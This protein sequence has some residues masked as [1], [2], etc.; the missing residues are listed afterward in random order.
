MGDPAIQSKPAADRAD[1]MMLPSS[2]VHALQ[3]VSMS[4]VHRAIH[5][6]GQRGRT[7]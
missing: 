6:T 3:P 2:A 1:M 5:A 4:V 7:T